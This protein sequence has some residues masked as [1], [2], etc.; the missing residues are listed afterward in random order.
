MRWLAFLL[1]AMVAASGQAMTE[2]LAAKK[3]G[4]EAPKAAPKAPEKPAAS[5]VKRF[6]DWA[7]A[8]REAKD[9]T[10]P[11]P[12]TLVQQLTDANS[13]KTVFNLT[14][15]YGPRG[16]LVLVVRAPLGIALAKGLE[17]SL[18]G[19][20]LQRAA[21]STCRPNGCQAVLIL[22]ND[23][24]QQMRKAEQALL[25]VYA[26]GGKPFQ[27]TASLKGFGDGLSALDKRRS[28]S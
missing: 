28:P 10:K 4:S 1:L 18:G 24:Q 7:L 26:L 13:K 11:A 2:P 16:N 14:V 3:P 8:C 21:F 17:L 15:G 12:C 20:T 5:V 25:T 22:A 6:G 23:L 9:K 19:Q 27:V